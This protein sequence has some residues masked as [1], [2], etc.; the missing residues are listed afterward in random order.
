M[1]RIHRFSILID[2]TWEHLEQL[3]QQQRCGSSSKCQVFASLYE[4]VKIIECLRVGPGAPVTDLLSPH[5]L[6]TDTTSGLRKVS[7]QLIVE[8]LQII[9]VISILSPPPT[10]LSPL[11]CCMQSKV[12]PQKLARLSLLIRLSTLP[13]HWRD[14]EP[15][16]LTIVEF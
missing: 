14:M 16:K 15:S 2:K 4:N 7:I 12:A 8:M 11:Q 1:W 3:S 10:C 5:N 9:T 13:R 6:D